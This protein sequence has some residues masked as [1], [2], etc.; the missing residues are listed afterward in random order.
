MDEELNN[1]QPS[2]DPYLQTIDDRTKSRALLEDKDTIDETAEIE[3]Q[4]PASDKFDPRDPK[5]DLTSNIPVLGPLKEHVLNPMSHGVADFVSDAVGIVPFL[6][7]VDRWWDENS[8]RSNH[9]A[10]KM[11][12]DASSVIIPS[13]AGGAAVVGSLRTV[14]LAAK[15]P[16]MVKTLAEVAAWAGVDTT[17]A[18][19]SSH[20]KTDD[21]LASV[22]NNWLG[23]DIPWATRAGDSADVTWKKNV[24]EAAGLSAGVEALGVLFA[25]GKRA[26]LFARDPVADQAIKARS[27]QLELFDNPITASVETRR[28]ARI[29][30]QTEE[31]VEVLKS[32]PLGE[33]GYNAFVNDL[34]P[35]DASK[36]VINLEPDPLMA[37][38]DQVTIQNNIG[39]KHGRMTPVASEAFNKKLMSA[40]NGSE[41]AKQL[42]K[43][44]DSI[45]P[46]FDAIVNDGVKDVKISAEQMNRSVDNLTASIFGRDLSFKEFEFIVDDMK[47]TVFNSNQFL[48]EEQWTIASKAFKNAYDRIFDPNQMRASA[49]ITQNAAENVADLASAAL[50]IGD[51]ADTSR[52]M[53]LIF[54]KL[55]LLSTEVK[56]NEFIVSRANEYKRLK[57]S[58]DTESIVKWMNRQGDEFDEYLTNVKRSSN[59]L[60]KELV[61]I[62]TN[63]PNYLKAF[64][65]IYDA[66]D[67]K[68]DNLDK[69][70]RFLEK[71][72][73]ILRNG[74]IN[75]DPEVPSLIV[76]GLHAARINGLL[77]GVAPIKALAT[78]ST[79]IALKPI[80]AFAGASVSNNRAALFKRS[81][82]TYKGISE[83][84]QRGLKQ[85]AHDWSVANKFPEQAMMRGRTDLRKA[86]LERLEW[87]DSV[88]EAWKAE[89]EFGKLANWYLARSLAWW[90]KQPFVRY[91][92]NALYAADGML[93]S[94]MASAMAR[95]TAYDEVLHKSK[96]AV[97]FDELYNHAQRRIYNT[98]FD[99]N[100]VLTDKAARH[101]AGEI[102]LNLDNTVVKNFQDFL[103]N[104]PAAKTLFLF[105][106]TGVNAF[107]LAWSFNP[108]SNIGPALT[109]ARRA[110]NARTAN[111]KLMSLAEHSITEESGQNLDIAFEAL[112]SEYIGRQ[113]MSHTVIYGAGIWA[114]EGNL[115]GAG[116]DDAAERMRLIS[117]GFKPWSIRNPITGEWKSYRN[118]EPFYS[119]MA[120]TADVIYQANR[121]DESV[122]QDT[123]NKISAAITMNI[124]NDTFIQGFEPLVG[125]FS[126][127]AGAWNKFWAQQVDLTIP[128]KGPRSILNNIVTPQL[129]DV[130][131]DF[132]EY[133]KNANKFLYRDN[134][135]L[136]DLYDIYTGEPIRYH[137]HFTH[138]VNA[139]L[140]T[141]KS[142]GGME[143]FRQWMLALGYDG[144]QRI[145]T[146][147]YTQKKLTPEDRQFISTYIAK[148]GN[149][150][151]KITALM[152][153][154]D[155]KWQSEIKDYVKNRGF[156]HQKDYPI[157]ETVIFRRL[158]QIHDEAF[159]EALRELKIKKD[160]YTVIGREIKNREHE[161]NRG[162]YSKAKETN[163]R[164]QELLRKTGNK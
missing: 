44:F 30:A 73:G 112:K 70:H 143:P 79:L 121:V 146:N 75:Q 95:A 163:K 87:M 85:M 58:G 98:M 45:S 64:K 160:E 33:K 111:E 158:D 13:L 116:P 40:I 3:K 88:G 129:K 124:T 145:R 152:L 22:I 131:N 99:D 37:K 35:D 42:D 31:A 43:L 19:I 24:M 148:N 155:D 161:L 7:P 130:K 90:T 51:E 162:K 14:P 82:Y 150:A 103:E 164:I 12:R 10:H 56:A 122:A 140:P 77:G 104:V 120:I 49:M 134:E 63:N 126:N 117:Q 114:L 68:V 102:A 20:S 74:I 110:L 118:F 18:M 91:G 57:Q 84:F 153:E 52:Q 97:N 100:G 142:N 6:K 23:W 50:M 96:G 16:A 92:I 46:N 93:N 8:P 5:N 119:L 62:A 29:A 80:A 61:E 105:P 123:L 156:S 28:N 34:G 53:G 67:G 115:T 65:E 106:K 157:K 139:F 128:F 151:N 55:N 135:K 159:E 59:K 144:V 71:N 2:L 1:T 72:M 11:I 83:N 81:F 113:M 125:L 136:K 141:F 86:H 41:R 25:F 9:P 54:K 133:L 78:N 69:M 66:T 89:G 36:A 108:L 26:K 48:D 107:E 21:N 76:K 60:E 154:K 15:T 109:R 94:F 38:L 147:K 132:G 137:D 101:A 17:V 39:T 127:D 138:A 47:S 4:I 32:D 149:L 27:K